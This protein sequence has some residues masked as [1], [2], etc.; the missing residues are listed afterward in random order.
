[1]SG[2]ARQAFR[3]HDDR[4]RVQALGW[5]AGRYAII[6]SDEGQRHEIGHFRHGSLLAGIG[7]KSPAHIGVRD[8]PPQIG[9]FGFQIFVRDNQRADRQRMSPSHVA[10]A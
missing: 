8:G 4:C 9:H 10:I 2:F 6:G 7:M 5:F 3:A 1:M